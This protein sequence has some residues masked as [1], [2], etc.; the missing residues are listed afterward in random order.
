MPMPRF[1]L[2]QADTWIVT[3]T[4]NGVAMPR[5]PGS[6]D[7][8]AVGY[9]SFDIRR[10]GD[11]VRFSAPDD[12]FSVTLFESP[13]FRFG[14]VARFQSGR[15]YADDRR[16]L[17]G[18]NDVEWALEPGVF[19][20]IWPTSFL[21][22]RIELRHGFHG[23][24]GFVGS[25]GADYVQPIGALTLSIGPRFQFGDSDYARRYFGVTPIEAI[26]NGRVT[27]YVAGGGF[28]Q[29]GVLAA[30]TYQLSDAW[31]VT[32]YGGYN[33]LIGDAA[34]SPI[35]RTLGTPNQFTFG[36]KV[37]YSFSMPALF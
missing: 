20:E 16:R 31:A 2:S 21:R 27:Q 19:A 23:H 5:F 25:I 4:G 11:P 24:N 36:A 6:R 33:R 34:R 12:G 3:V 7:Y 9:P 13:A 10:A 14:P 1:V 8:T 18:L 29:A 35:V 15:Y 17:F 37:S 30:A 22:T 32:A 28:N 26:L